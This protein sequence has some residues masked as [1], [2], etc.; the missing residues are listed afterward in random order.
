MFR[1]IIIVLVFSSVQV[2]SE[3]NGVV[4]DGTATEFS[5]LR[6]IVSCELPNN[7]TN[8]FNGNVWNLQ[9][10][11]KTVYRQITVRQ[12]NK[13]NQMVDVNESINIQNILLRGCVLKNTE[14]VIGAVISTGTDTK[15]E[16][17][18]EKKKW[19][20]VKVYQ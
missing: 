1:N 11:S 12:M 10:L 19:W 4:V 17:G 20:S 9:M 14:S 15:V 7:M 18:V 3:Q 6:A 5:E 16:Y 2:T 13:Y 8:D